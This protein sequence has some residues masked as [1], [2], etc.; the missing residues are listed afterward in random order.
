MGIGFLVDP[1]KMFLT[2]K[3][4]LRSDRDQLCPLKVLLPI[5]AKAM[6]E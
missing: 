4:G 2:A 6:A 5:V 1:S 3:A